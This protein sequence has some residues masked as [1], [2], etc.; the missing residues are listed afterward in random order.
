MPNENINL[1]NNEMN[2]NNTQEQSFLESNNQVDELLNNVENNEINREVSKKKNNKKIIILI[3]IILVVIIVGVLAFFLLSKDDKVT[4]NDNKTNNNTPVNNDGSNE[5]VNKDNSSKILADLKLDEDVKEVKDKKY[6]I[7]K[8][9]DG[10]FEIY[11]ESDNEPYEGDKLV[12][13]YICQDDCIFVNGGFIHED[14]SIEVFNYSNG[15]IEKLTLNKKYN[16]IDKDL[17]IEKYTLGKNT[18]YYGEYKGSKAF[19]KTEEN[20]TM[21]LSF[22]RYNLFI[23]SNVNLMEKG[24][25]VLASAKS[26]GKLMYEIFENATS[27]VGYNESGDDEFFDVSLEMSGDNYK[28][29]ASVMDGDSYYIILNKKFDKI[30]DYYDY[31]DT[32]ILNNNEYYCYMGIVD[33]EDNYSTKLSKFNQDGKETIIKQY[34]AVIGLTDDLIVMGMTKEKYYEIYDVKNNK[35]IYNFDKLTSSQS[36]CYHSYFDNYNY[37]DKK[38]NTF[39]AFVDDESLTEKDFPNE[40]HDPEEDNYVNMFGYEY[41]YN[42]KTGQKSVTKKATYTQEE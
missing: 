26:D 25:Y 7:Y 1:E 2:S 27:K 38:T 19:A 5:D 16:T 13:T 8:T 41:T 42:V 40:N 23:G 3:A 15:K 30:V 29:N 17:S 4:N 35:V 28:I 20:D 21:S 39:H 37:F 11:P 32:C 31:N 22:D 14:K 6:F 33:S 18:Y 10:I 24:T 12:T 36:Q 9:T 34:E